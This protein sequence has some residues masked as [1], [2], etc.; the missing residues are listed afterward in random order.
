MT[1]VASGQLNM[2]AI[3]AEYGAGQTDSKL[4]DFY[5]GAGGAKWVRANSGDNGAVNLSAGVPATQTDLKYSHFY[6]QAK[7][8]QYT[9][10]TVRVPSPS[11]YHCHVEFGS[12]WLGANGTNWPC[13]YINNNGIY[14][15]STSYYA[16]VIYGRQD[17]GPFTFTNNSE[18]QG[19]GGAPNSGAGQ[20]AVY[21]YNSE[22][23]SYA[24]RPII[25]NNYAIRGGG[26]AGG[27]GGQGGTGGQGYY[28]YTAQDGPTYQ[29]WGYDLVE[30]T[31]GS[32]G[33]CDIYWAGSLIYDQYQPPFP[34]IGIGGYT[35]YQGAVQIDQGGGAGHYAIYRQYTATQ[36]TGGGGGGAGGNGGRGIGY[37]S[38]N[39]GGNGGAPGAGGS[40]NAGSGGYGGTGGTGGSWGENGQTGGTGATGN[41]GNA[42][43][44]S[45]GAG[46]G[47]GGAAGYCVYAA[48]KWGFANNNTLNGPYG[49]GVANT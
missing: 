16:L 31:G 10:T 17:N 11:H 35:Y 2:S 14:S 48:T 38:P 6:G 20:H 37:N 39:Q 43:G 18:I 33:I 27:V 41:G 45:P 23:A 24:N 9:N 12:D 34:P 1:I 44:G 40:T 15:T 47:G 19:A 30:R 28:N 49:G 46:G 22:N 42:G 32:H 13:Y 4:G 29:T 36:Y 3:A 26:G 8:W 5:R 21:I 25:I 7:G